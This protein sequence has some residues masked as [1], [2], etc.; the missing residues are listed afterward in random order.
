MS[1]ITKSLAK[2]FN[3]PSEP[4]EKEM[5]LD[6]IGD[7]GSVLK[8]MEVLATDMYDGFS[9]QVIQ[10]RPLSSRLISLLPKFIQPD[11]VR[12]QNERLNEIST[13]KAKMKYLQDTLTNIRDSIESM[14]FGSS[15]R[16]ESYIGEQIYELAYPGEKV[17][18]TNIETLEERLK[19]LENSF[20]TSMDKINDQLG[21]ISMNL[22]TLKNR[23]DEQNVKIDRIDEKISEVDSKLKKIQSSLATISRKLTQ[24]RTLLALLAGSVVALIIVV[25]IM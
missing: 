1:V 5:L 20:L 11:S 22:K 25:I 6:F 3:K 10:K 16:D 18:P 4:T 17:D 24:N 8:S 9:D 7:L 12:H 21:Q 13:A 23:L 15:T 19:I 2:W 14:E